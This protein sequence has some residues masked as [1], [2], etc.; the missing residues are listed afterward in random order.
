MIPECG[1]G[2]PLWSGLKY[3]LCTQAFERQVDVLSR[4]L[5]ANIGTAEGMSRDRQALQEHLRAAEQVTPMN[6][7]LVWQPSPSCDGEGPQAK[8]HLRTFRPRRLTF[9]FVSDVSSIW[10]CATHGCSMFSIQIKYATAP[11]GQAI[12]I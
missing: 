12:S 3:G 10:C 11:E 8:D 1:D 7:L 2:Q 6:P 4:Q 9:A 5:S